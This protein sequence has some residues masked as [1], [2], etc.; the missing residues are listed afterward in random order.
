MNAARYPQEV[1]GVTA[2][3]GAHPSLADAR[4]TCVVCS[5]RRCRSTFV[6]LFKYLGSSASGDELTLL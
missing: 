5:R 6:S 3:R 4:Y 2:E 1:V